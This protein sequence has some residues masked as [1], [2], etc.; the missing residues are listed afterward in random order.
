MK[1]TA[2]KGS[3]STED[4]FQFH[5]VNDSDI[6]EILADIFD[7]Y[8]RWDDFELGGNTLYEHLMRGEYSLSSLRLE[9][10]FVYLFFTP[11]TIHL[12]IRRTGNFEKLIKRLLD[13]FEY[14]KYEPK[15][16]MANSSAS[17]PKA[18]N[19]ARQKDKPPIKNQSDKSA[20]KTGAVVGQVDSIELGSQE[21]FGYRIVMVDG[22]KKFEYPPFDKDKKHSDN[23]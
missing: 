14:V 2:I 8:D 21:D 18:T 6:F 12:L 4:M 3:S 9:N 5:L 19:K 13:H 22:K 10:S 20:S 17:I 11:S 7:L 1:K 16:S 23:G 15:D